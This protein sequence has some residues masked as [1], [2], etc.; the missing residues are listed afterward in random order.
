MSS[1]KNE[2]QSRN[3]T[4]TTTGDGSNTGTDSGVQK[5]VSAASSELVGELGSSDVVATSGR[6]LPGV[7]TNGNEPG[8]VP[9]GSGLGE[10]APAG[11]DNSGSGG[12]P[13][14][15][16]KD[17]GISVLDVELFQ[18]Q[19]PD[20]KQFTAYQTTNEKYVKCTSDESVP[21]LYGS[22]EASDEDIKAVISK[23]FP[24]PN[25][26]TGELD[27]ARDARGSEGVSN[28]NAEPIEEPVVSEAPP[29]EEIM[30]DGSLIR[31]AALDGIAQL[32]ANEGLFLH[33]DEYTVPPL[34]SLRARPGANFEGPITEFPGALK[35]AHLWLVKPETATE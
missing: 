19:A 35:L 14:G 11:D 31:G 27:V 8:T 23:K 22:L 4:I 2:Q 15:S 1:K 10:T 12:E 13:L 9:L 5:T 21:N 30:L 16:P 25:P 29:I 17:D 34:Y 18:F 20:G 3:S 33:I 24:A 7:D 28:D 26:A 6:N 32:V